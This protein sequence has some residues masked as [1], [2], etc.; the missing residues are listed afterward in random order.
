MKSEPTEEVLEL[1]MKTSRRKWVIW[2]LIP[3]KLLLFYMTLDQPLYLESNR[4]YF[5]WNGN[6][7][8][9]DVIWEKIEICICFIIN[10][11][12]FFLHM[13]P[14]MFDISCYLEIQLFQD[15]R[16]VIILKMAK[17]LWLTHQKTWLLV[18]CNLIC[19]FG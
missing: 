2:V 14:T 17:K 12:E 4:F 13:R 5:L 10:T 18:S 9:F 7:F 6:Y 15:N 11:Q 3:A 8:L 1:K 19:D 16:Q